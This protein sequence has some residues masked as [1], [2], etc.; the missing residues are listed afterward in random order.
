M[1]YNIKEMMIGLM[2][3]IG[4]MCL[5]N[6]LVFCLIL[7]QEIWVFNVF[8]NFDNERLNVCII[9]KMYFELFIFE[10]YMKSFIEC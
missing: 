5:I 4:M 8:L 3:K 7:Y 10:E 1:D 9:D 6:S 2:G